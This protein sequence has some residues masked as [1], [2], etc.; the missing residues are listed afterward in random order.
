MTI[1]VNITPCRSDILDKTIR[2]GIIPVGDHTKTKL[3][4]PPRSLGAPPERLEISQWRPMALAPRAPPP[5]Q[6]AVLRSTA[7][8][9]RWRLPLCCPYEHR[10]GAPNSE[11]GVGF[12]LRVH[13]EGSFDLRHSVSNRTKERVQPSRIESFNPLVTLARS[14]TLFSP[15]RPSLL[16]IQCASPTCATRRGI[17]LGFLVEQC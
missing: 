17:H 14:Q 4:I 12:V 6:I 15:E 13:E 5:R 1:V 16:P 3:R 7:R 9:Q 8:C 10:I 11:D 2:R